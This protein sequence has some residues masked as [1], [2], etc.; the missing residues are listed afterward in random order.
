VARGAGTEK[1]GGGAIDF[2]MYVHGLPFVDAVKFP[3]DRPCGL[4]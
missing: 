3:I 4:F 1:G 2:A